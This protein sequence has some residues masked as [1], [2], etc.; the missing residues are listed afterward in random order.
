MASGSIAEDKKETDKPKETKL[1]GNLLCAKCTLKEK[2]ITKC[3]N[4]LQVKDGDKVVTYF[5]DDKGT[6]ESY[7]EGICGAGAKKEATVTGVVSEK[8]GKKW[9]KPSKVELKKT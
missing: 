3:T 2:G 7:H 6:K 8:D 9:I 1:S 4:A 5:L